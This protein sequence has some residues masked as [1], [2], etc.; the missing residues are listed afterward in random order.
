MSMVIIVVFKYVDASLSM[1]WNPGIILRLF[2]CPVN[3]VKA[4]IIYLSLIFFV[5]VFRMA[6]QSYT[7]MTCMDVFPLLDVVRKRPHIS[8]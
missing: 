7:C 3:S 8:E 4:R 2:K 1:K 5:A 6:L